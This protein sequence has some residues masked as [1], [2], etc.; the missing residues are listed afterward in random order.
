MNANDGLKPEM[1]LHQSSP[2][3]CFEEAKTSFEKT[4]EEVKAS[5]EQP[6][7]EAKRNY[8]KD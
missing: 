1:Q 5:I 8:G 2:E 7:K 3:D 6:L 4:L